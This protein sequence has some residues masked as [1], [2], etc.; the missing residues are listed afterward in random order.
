MQ[1]GFS[2]FWTVSGFLQELFKIF[3]RSWLPKTNFRSYPCEREEI[4]HPL[5]PRLRKEVKK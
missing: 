3:L 1:L 2:A 4:Y 5:S